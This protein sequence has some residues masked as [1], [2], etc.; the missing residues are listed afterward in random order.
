MYRWQEPA[1]SQ[2]AAT[3]YVRVSW[4]DVPESTRDSVRMLRHWLQKDLGVRFDIEWWRSEHDE[5]GAAEAKFE[6]ALKRVLNPYTMPT[7]QDDD[8]NWSGQVM[9][10]RP[11][12]V[13]L[14]IEVNPKNLLYTCAHEARHVWQLKNFEDFI[15]AYLI[16]KKDIAGIRYRM[17]QDA[18]QYAQK[19]VQEYKRGAKK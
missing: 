5:Y 3:T 11:E 13:R 14:N 17:E 8:E 15:P 18:E 6:A 16:Q 10:K 4:R 9:T 12:V 7:A 2:K 19:A 1:R